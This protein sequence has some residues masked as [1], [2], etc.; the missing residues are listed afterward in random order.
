MSEQIQSQVIS[1][2]KVLFL[3]GLAASLAVPA[4]ALTA[5]DVKAQQP[6]EQAAPAEKASP[7][8]KKEKEGESYPVRGS[9]VRH[10]AA[11]YATEGTVITNGPVA[12]AETGS[13]T[14]AL[15]YPACR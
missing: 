3:V 10:S 13:W 6:S 2:R 11:D 1:R 7:K 8:K 4:T 15:S 12:L 9:P 5:S 14:G